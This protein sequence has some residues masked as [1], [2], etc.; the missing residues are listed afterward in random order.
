MIDNFK[1]RLGSGN[2]TAEEQANMMA[3]LQAKMAQINDALEDEQDSQ[4]KALQEAIARRR[5]KRNQLRNVMD[6]ITDKKDTEDEYY[7]KK[8]GEIQKMEEAENEK[9][10]QE[11]NDE[12]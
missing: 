5:A 10:E 4:N 2:L 7:K 11:I 6:D 1:M 3:D 12:R 9:I 8:I